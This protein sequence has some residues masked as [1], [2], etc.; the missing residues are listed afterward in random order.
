[1]EFSKIFFHTSHRPYP[2]PNKSWLMKQTWYDLLFMHWEIPVSHLLPFIPAG[3]ECDTFQEKAYIGIVPFGMSN[4]RYRFLP[5]IPFT[6]AFLELNVRT[7]VKKNNIAGVLF[8]SL[9]AANPIAVEVA[10]AFF[11]LPYFNAKMSLK[12][13]GSKIY[14]SS[15]RKDKRGNPA[16]L[17]IEYQPTSKIYHSIPNTLEHWLTERYCLYSINKKGILYRTDIHHIPWP[18]QEAKAKILENTMAQS[19]GIAIPNVSPIL[20][21][22]EKIEVAIYAPTTQ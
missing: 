10:R 2:L 12:K 20:H 8:L 18:L 16:S 17:K 7:Y 4:I 6:S 21:F 3:L 14:Y 19:H 15:T 22:A 11:Y 13:Q 5:P 9:D 1:M